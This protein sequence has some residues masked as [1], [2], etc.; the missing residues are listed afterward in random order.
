MRIQ[1]LMTACVSALLANA[2]HAAAPAP[3]SRPRVAVVNAV[4]FPANIPE[5]AAK[6]RD[7]LIGAV[8]QHGYD[9]AA[10]QGTCVD[11]A[12][13]QS[14]AAKTRATDVL[15]AAG[16]QNVLHGYHVELRIWNVASDRDD[17][18][19]AECNVCTGDQIVE[20]VSGSARQLLDRVP[21]LHA[22]VAP[23][24]APP[25]APLPPALSPVASP[26]VIASPAGSRTPVVERST[27]PIWT[28]GAGGAALVAGLAVG[29]FVGE[30]S[31]CSNAS[32]AECFLTYDY[33]PLGYTMA[34]VGAIVAATGAYFLFT[35]SGSAET[36]GVSVAVSPAGL[37]V[38]GHF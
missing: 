31:G 22:L 20:T 6:L 33:R 1:L 30:R 27:W 34:G 11:R 35:E 25:V 18:S 9:L 14:L 15:V 16:G 10:D 32:A 8:K 4:E 2:A 28:L 36:K 19:T 29:I 13:L 26:N 3:G 5:V 12:C 37:S 38:G 21:V 17:R 7:A 24:A 23:S